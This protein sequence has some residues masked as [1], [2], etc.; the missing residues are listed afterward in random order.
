M[1]DFE[2]QLGLQTGLGMRVS[3]T[4]VALAGLVTLS[5]TELETVVERELTTNPALE[6]GE[7]PGCPV[8][9]DG[10]HS[11]ATCQAGR[12]RTRQPRPG[13]DEHGARVQ[14]SA[15]AARSSGVERLASEA[16]LLVPSADRRVVEYVAADL[17]GRGRLDREPATL[18]AELGVTEERVHRA[19]AAIRE[20]GPPGI[21]ARDLSDCLRLQLEPMEADAGA[22]ALLRRILDGHLEDLARGR[23]RVVAAA[24]GVT[25]TDVAAARDLLRRLQPSAVVDDAGEQTPAARPDVVVRKGHGRLGELEV[26]VADEAWRGLR[27]EPLYRR[28]ASGLASLPLTASERRHVCE[29]VARADDLLARLAERSTVLGRVARCAVERQRGFLRDGPAA[30]LPLTRAEVARELGMHESTVSRAVNGKHVQL[31]DGRLVPMAELFGT[32]RS[33]QELLR[34]VVAAETRP[35]SDEQLADRLSA[36]GHTVARRTVAK[37]RARLGIPPAAMR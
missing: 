11:A 21:C 32:A 24:H 25:T 13:P 6:C 1:P 9:G 27:V 15:I 35:L 20:V 16:G 29:Q 4:V 8:C 28:L 18:A 37:Y 5:A 26:E 23:L 17:D 33:A 3:P 19:I 12:D 31:P 30:H 10:A 36:G 22:P 7:P 2:S 34:T 14:L